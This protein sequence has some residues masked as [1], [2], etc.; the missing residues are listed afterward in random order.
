MPEL[1]TEQLLLEAVG[2]LDRISERLGKDIYVGNRRPGEYTDNEY[3]LVKL[4]N[5][6]VCN[7]D[8]VV[9]LYE[10]MGKHAEWETSRAA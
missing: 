8:P 7:P 4:G 6:S 3:Y 2:L 1:T 9:A 5:L 10:V